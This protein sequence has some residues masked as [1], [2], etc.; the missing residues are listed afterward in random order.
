MR[1]EENLW[2]MF[3]GLRVFP[4]ALS[5]E[6]E[7]EAKTQHINHFWTKPANQKR[8]MSKTAF[9]WDAQNRT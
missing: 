1:W 4:F 3:E 8:K 5:M 7:F 6:H 9:K 2:N